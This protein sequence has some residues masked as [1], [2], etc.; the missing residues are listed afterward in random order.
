MEPRLTPVEMDHWL[1][2]TCHPEI[3]CFNACCHDLNHFLY[4][5]DVLRLCRHLE[6]SSGTFLE[7]YARIH[8]G[9]ETGLPVATLRLDPV[10]NMA[11]PFV[12]AAG[13]TVY[14]DRPAACRL[15]PLARAVRR[16]A[17]TGR[18]TEH[19]ALLQEPHCLGHGSGRRRRVAD[20]IQDQGL[21]P[22]HRMNDPFVEVIAIKRRACPGPLSLA[23]SQLVGQALY[24]LDRFR[25][26]ILSR[27]GGDPLSASATECERL[28]DDDEALLTF[29]YRWVAALLQGTARPGPGMPVG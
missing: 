10:R 29:A 19:F 27:P 8:Q 9:P 6:L 7:R 1:D 26:R 3:P 25:A 11:C 21:V 22:Y 16:C 20:W 18:R 4:P 15:Y 24:D 17:E 12:G 5:Y 23:H 28:A 14:S 2:F 13:C